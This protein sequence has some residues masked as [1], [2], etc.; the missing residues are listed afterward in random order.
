[1]SGGIPK[2]EGICEKT[3]IDSSHDMDE[4]Q[5]C[6]NNDNE[7]AKFS[8]QKLIHVGEGEITYGELPTAPPAWCVSSSRRIRI[9]MPS[10]A[11]VKVIFINLKSLSSF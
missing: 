5:G 11:V 10:A 3:N 7:T 9:A 1:M 4:R 2:K 8:D 6:K